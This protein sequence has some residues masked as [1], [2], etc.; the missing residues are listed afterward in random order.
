VINLPDLYLP[1]SAFS[2]VSAVNSP[3]SAQEIHRRVRGDRRDGT[4]LGLNQTLSAAR[5]SFRKFIDEP[6]NTVPEQPDIE[7][8]EQAGLVSRKFEI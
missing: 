2:A 4:W 8:D 5:T 6:S 7:I 1:F 3:V